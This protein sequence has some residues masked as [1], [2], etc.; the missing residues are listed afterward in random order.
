M[1]I[2]KTIKHS[3]STLLHMFVPV[4]RG[5]ALY[6]ACPFHDFS[7]MILQ[8]HSSP[9]S[10]ASDRCSFGSGKRGGGFGS[11]QGAPGPGTYQPQFNGGRQGASWTM[12]GRTPIA[13]N[14][15][16]TPGP[17][18]YAN[19]IPKSNAPAYGVGTSSRGAFS[20]P[21]S[22]GPGA[23]DARCN[24]GGQSPQWRW[25]LVIEKLSGWLTGMPKRPSHVPPPPRPPHGPAESVHRLAKL[26]LHGERISLPM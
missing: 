25:V 15:S 9:C 10:A 20:S 26:T 18:A 6:G 8:T 3:S 12:A 5:N 21:A 22:P 14:R 24:F 16:V 23:Y 11:R 17:G 2:T 19:V 13:G 1:R 7:P 4:T